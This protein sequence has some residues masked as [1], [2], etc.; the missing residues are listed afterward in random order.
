MTKLNRVFRA[1]PAICARPG[2][3]VAQLAQVPAR[4]DLAAWQDRL[5]AA[6]VA[7]ATGTPGPGGRLTCV[8]SLPACAPRYPTMP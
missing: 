8:P 5:R 3:L 4:H 2:S 7:F 1:D 6:R